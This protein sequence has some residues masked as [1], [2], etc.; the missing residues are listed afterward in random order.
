MSDH[1]TRYPSMAHGADSSQGAG[2]QSTTQ[3][4]G[5][6]DVDEG[7]RA[8]YPSMFDGHD[9]ARNEQWNSPAGPRDDRYPSMKARDDGRHADPDDGHDAAEQESLRE[10][11]PT[12]RKGEA[13]EGPERGQ[14]GPEG[15]EAGQDI[16]EVVSGALGPTVAPEDAARVSASFAKAGLTGDQAKAVLELHAQEQAQQA[17]AHDAQVRSWQEQ[18]MADP[19]IVEGLDD[20]KALLAH[21][22]HGGKVRA[23]LEETGYGAHPAVVKMLV[24]MA[25]GG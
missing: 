8:R 3:P 1:N 2:E 24:R 6:N 5:G 11:Y 21:Y 14:D 13:E 7:L 15:R 10:R 23:L 16:G 17:K 19:E 22:D 12:M 18:S 4:S 25:T 9:Q 20:A